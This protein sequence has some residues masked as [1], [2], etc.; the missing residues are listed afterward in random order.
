MPEYAS[1]LKLKALT[2]VTAENTV[3]SWG[4]IFGWIRKF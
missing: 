2:S 1:T 4:V 3:R